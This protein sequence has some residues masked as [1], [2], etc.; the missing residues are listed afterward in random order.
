MICVTLTEPLRL[1]RA[2]KSRAGLDAV[3]ASRRGQIL[4]LL[5]GIRDLFLAF[6]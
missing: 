4:V 5:G 2:C 6:N 3:S 1:N